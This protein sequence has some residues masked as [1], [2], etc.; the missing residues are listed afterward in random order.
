MSAEDADG[1]SVHCTVLWS[2]VRGSVPLSAVDPKVV[3]GQ[4]NRYLD[5]VAAAVGSA[6]GM[7][8]TFRGGSVS[9]S[10]GAWEPDEQHASHACAAASDMLVR[11]ERVNQ[12][13]AADGLVSLELNIGIATG[14]AVAGSIGPGG[15][16]RPCIIGD[17]ATLAARLEGAATRLGTPIV[18]SRETARALEPEQVRSLGWAEVR[19]VGEPVQVATLAWLAGVSDAE[20]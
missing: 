5:E 10:F 15:A 16:R 4:L 17:V 12:Q 14:A 6:G 20:D 19:G 7:I 13:R 1:R 8:D 18:L 2:E 3:V 9:A 11:L